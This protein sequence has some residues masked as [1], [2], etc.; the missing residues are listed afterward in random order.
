MLQLLENLAGVCCGDFA[1]EITI[2]AQFSGMEQFDQV[3]GQERGCTYSQLVLLAI[4]CLL[5]IMNALIGDPD[6]RN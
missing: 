4:F 1:G 2:Q 5:C 3:R 6:A